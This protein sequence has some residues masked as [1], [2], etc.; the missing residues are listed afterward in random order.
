M[1][2]CVLNRTVKCEISKFK[3]K[4]KKFVMA[5]KQ[6][7]HNHDMN[8][9]SVFF[10][11]SL[12]VSKCVLWCNACVCVCV[13]EYSIFFLGTDSL[14]KKFDSL[15]FSHCKE[16]NFQWNKESENREREWEKEEKWPRNLLIDW[17]R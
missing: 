15:F 6:Q 3:A 7:Q 16:S 4:Q 10:Y 13:C 11:C 8:V 12:A 14:C 5:N 2:V 1:C 17:F 9:D